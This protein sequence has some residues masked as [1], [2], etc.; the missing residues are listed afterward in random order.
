M[1]EK[2]K[3]HT[4]K[5]LEKFKNIKHI[6]IYVAIIF[7]VIIILIFFS[8]RSTKDKDKTILTNE[9]TVT[10]YIDKLEEDL[11]KI[12]SNISGVSNV[13]VMITICLNDLEVKDNQVHISKFPQIN[14]ILVTAKGVNDTA[15][16]L[17]V[18]HAI[19]A[20]IEVENGN[21]EIL[22]SE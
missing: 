5:W 21:V 4:I 3:K 18:L 10:Q 15:T 9:I 14:G 11:E 12:L 19:E 22:S 1:S 13:N 17:R 20:V 16:K 2:E 7:I 6:E 8:N